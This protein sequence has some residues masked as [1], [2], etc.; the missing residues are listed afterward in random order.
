MNARF[1]DGLRP[2][3][4]GDSFAPMYHGV[5]R[6]IFT[7]RPLWRRITLRGWLWIVATV[8]SVSFYAW[9]LGSLK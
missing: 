2:P 8:A 3:R 4:R 7:K 9:V 5:A 6:E 1:R